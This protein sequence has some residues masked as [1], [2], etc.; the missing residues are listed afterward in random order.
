V[1]RV[2]A[3]LGL[4][5]NAERSIK[6][7]VS[8]YERAGMRMSDPKFADLEDQARVSEIVVES[9][10]QREDQMIIE[11]CQF[12]TFAVILSGLKKDTLLPWIYSSDNNSDT[13][14]EDI[15]YMDQSDEGSDSGEERALDLP[16]VAIQQ[17]EYEEDWIE[18]D[19]A[20]STPGLGLRKKAPSGSAC[21]K[22]KKWKKRC[23][24]D[25]PMRKP[26]FKRATSTNLLKELQ[27]AS[28]VSQELDLEAIERFEGLL[29]NLDNHNWELF[30]QKFLLNVISAVKRNHYDKQLA[31]PNT[32]SECT[33]L[34][35]LLNKRHEWETLLDEL[36]H[37]A[38]NP[39]CSNSVVQ[40]EA[41]EER[42]E[43][44]NFTE[45]DSIK[46][47]L[48]PR[49]QTLGRTKRVLSEIED[50][51]LSCKYRTSEQEVTTDSDLQHPES[52]EQT[53]DSRYLAKRQKKDSME[54]SPYSEFKKK[55]IA[56][57][58]SRRKVKRNSNGGR[59]G[60]KYLPQACERHK[61]L[62]AR[63][64]SN[65]PDRILRD[66]VS[67]QS[68]EEQIQEENCD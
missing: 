11:D 16:K 23:P 39:S 60:R 33:T 17:T 34:M 50:N 8:S 51:T 19:S 25:C 42:D 24:D 53:E 22:H 64:P 46:H 30:K 2:S 21:E 9:Q 29:K 31:K 62:H 65:C 35:R 32:R 18:F 38:R 1:E 40:K 6:N 3:S 63:C 57:S 59:I 68:D 54:V 47:G 36:Q 20:G 43:E 49:L 10:I 28:Y 7:V 41:K 56:R 27:T 45:L 66:S 58:L 44:Q 4:R 37:M 13:L 26:K 55:H 15:S 67:T 52:P 48:Q 14:Q 5:S 61:L 12:E